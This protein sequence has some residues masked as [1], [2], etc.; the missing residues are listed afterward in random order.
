MVAYTRMKSWLCLIS[1]VAAAGCSAPPATPPPTTP[2]GPVVKREAFG[3]VA[4]RPVEQLTLTNKNGVEIRAITYGGII[5]SIKTPDRA[6]AMGDIVLG[7]DSIDGYLGGHPYFGAIIGRY[8]N[9]IAKGRFTIDTQEYTLATNNGPNHLHGGIKGFDKQIWSAEILPPM[10]GQSSVVFAYTSA[11]G[12][13]GYPGKL[14]VEVTYTLNDS[15]E[16]TVDYLARTDKATH[17]NLTQHSYFNL[18]GGGDILGHELTIGADRYT[19]VDATL[20]PTGEIA[21]VE[22]TPFDFR[23]ST[24]IGAR[25]DAPHPQIKVGPGYDHNWVLNRTGD[26]LKHAARVIEPRSGRTLDVSTTE[27][28]MQFYAGNF[29]DGKL[30]G[31]GGQSYGRRSGFCLETQHFPDAPNQPGFPTTLVKPGQE[32]KSRTVFTFGATK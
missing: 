32:Y 5:T 12:E 7:F 10:A 16:L 3:T 13:E 8:G 29:L 26:G 14:I 25:I 23:Q 2:A 30:I 18:A 22:G 1:L 15:N 11:D 17:V 20:I 28:G 9:R 4:G 24:A 21:P 27:P 19:P 31:K 6:G